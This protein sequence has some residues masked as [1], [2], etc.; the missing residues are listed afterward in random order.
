M[1]AVTMIHHTHTHTHTSA[2]G[3][4]VLV[5]DGLVS[6][7]VSVCARSLTHTACIRA[8]RSK[9][10]VFVLHTIHTHTHTPQPLVSW[11]C[12]EA[13]TCWV[14]TVRAHVSATCC[15]PL[16]RSP[17]EGGEEALRLSIVVFSIEVQA[18]APACQQIQ[19]GWGCIC[20][21]L[22]PWKI[23]LLQQN[24][25]REARSSNTV[26]NSCSTCT[27]AHTQYVHA[28]TFNSYQNVRLNICSRFCFRPGNFLAHFQKQHLLTPAA[29]HV[30]LI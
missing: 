7:C 15:P 1:I 30:Q 8:C 19:A 4:M 11:C 12:S 28:E 20:A 22:Q 16:S 5:G 2:H 25:K 24:A 29:V 17:G 23:L 18:A 21:V 26:S 14:L 3:V 9:W 10:L 13:D 6:G 27:N